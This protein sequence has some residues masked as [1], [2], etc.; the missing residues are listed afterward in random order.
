MEW[1][2]TAKHFVGNNSCRR[3]VWVFDHFVGLA[4]KG[5]SE[6]NGYDRDRCDMVI[7]VNL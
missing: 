6:V 2:S 3:I 5:L 1:S 7:Y 4:T